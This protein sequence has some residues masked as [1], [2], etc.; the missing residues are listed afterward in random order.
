MV[1]TGTFDA[2]HPTSP[3][4]ILQRTGLMSEAEK[5]R[6]QILIPVAAPNA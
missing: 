3:H 4:R 1:V 6:C 5:K 2:P